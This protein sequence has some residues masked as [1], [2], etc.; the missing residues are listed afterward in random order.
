MF[1]GVGLLLLALLAA[2]LVVALER[3]WKSGAGAGRTHRHGAT[4]GATGPG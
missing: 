3:A 1:A 4:R 2:A